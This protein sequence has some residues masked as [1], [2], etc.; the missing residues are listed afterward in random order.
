MNSYHIAIDTIR[1]IL[2]NHPDVNTVVHGK[3]NEKD[4]YKKSIYPLAHINPIGSSFA[5][6]QENVFV[7]EIAVLDQRDLS[8][9]NLVEDKFDGNDNLIDNLNTC[10]AVLN[11][12]ITRLRLQENNGLELLTVSDATPVL[13]TDHNIMD[14]WL[15]TITVALPNTVIAV[16]S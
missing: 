11:N 3:T 4:L 8:T 10:H 14:G 9:N 2:K 16:C 5:S 15:I 13:F 6:S 1:T 12:L 7:F